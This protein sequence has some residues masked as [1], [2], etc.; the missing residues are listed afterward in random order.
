MHMISMDCLGACRPIAHKSVDCVAEHTF[1]DATLRMS[2]RVAT[3]LAELESPELLSVPLPLPFGQ[4]LMLGPV[5]WSYERQG[6][7]ATLTAKKLDELLGRL[8]E[9]KSDRS[10]SVVLTPGQ[11]APE[12]PDDEMSYESSEY[13]S[14]AESEEFEEEGGEEDE[15]EEDA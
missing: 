12:K 4:R 15:D 5:L 3:S 2:G 7:A 1:G 9:C 10:E 13:M 14:E 8:K 11:T 6:T